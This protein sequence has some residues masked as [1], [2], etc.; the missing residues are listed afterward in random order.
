MPFSETRTRAGAKRQAFGREYLLDHNATA[1]AIRAGYSEKSA[2]QI[3]YKL[4]QSAD[5]R[6][7][8][9]EHVERQEWTVDRVLAVLGG[10]AEDTT[11]KA[12]DRRAAASDIGK[13][14]GM[15]RDRVELSGPNGGAI[16]TSVQ[17]EFVR[18]DGN[19]QADSV[20]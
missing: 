12:A 19:G 11:Q 2:K 1:A 15:F 14:L 18:S 7:M 9:A 5:V 6:A 20:P 4:M 10:I 3:G 8:L 16:Q 17:I 13:Y